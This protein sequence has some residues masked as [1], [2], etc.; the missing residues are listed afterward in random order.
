MANIR[1]ADG[2][3]E[4]NAMPFEYRQRVSARVGNN[5]KRLQA[6]DGLT[7]YEI[8][9][10]TGIGHTTLYNWCTE[11]TVPAIDKLLW[12]CGKCGWKLSDLLAK[13]A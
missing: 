11:R 5:I 1:R 10:R 13:E 7:L 2:G 8:E 6:R 9:Q 12:M 3:A 4:E